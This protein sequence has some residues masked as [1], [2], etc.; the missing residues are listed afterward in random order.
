MVAPRRFWWSFRYYHAVNKSIRKAWRQYRS[1]PPVRRELATL[2]LMLLVAL[3]VLPLAIWI[4]GKLFL[5]DYLRTP[6]DP[7]GNTATGGPLAL[8]ADFVGGVAAGSPGHWLVLLGPY[9]LLMAL[10]GARAISRT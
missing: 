9:L 3:T 2:A 7:S 4:A 6:P 8:L 5:G 10:R 1:L